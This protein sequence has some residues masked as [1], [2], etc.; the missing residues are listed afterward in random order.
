MS[1]RACGFG[2]VLR[3]LVP[4]RP[5]TF[6]GIA[7]PDLLEV[8]R[9]SGTVLLR[10]REGEVSPH[11]ILQRTRRFPGSSACFLIGRCGQREDEHEYAQELSHAPT[12]ALVRLA[13][14]TA[15]GEPCPAALGTATENVAQCPSSA[16]RREFSQKRPRSNPPAQALKRP[17]ISGTYAFRQKDLPCPREWF[18]YPLPRDGP[19]AD[20][21]GPEY[22]ES[23]WFHYQ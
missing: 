12:V 22:R 7:S 11:P 8:H 19:R 15:L 3:E 17:A 16:I 14:T 18:I 10:Q 4:V 20:A 21:R 1:S 5:L 6:R 23:C 2:A 13:R 9:E